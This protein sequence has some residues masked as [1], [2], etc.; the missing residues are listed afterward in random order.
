[1]SIYSY[2]ND[3]PQMRALNNSSLTPVELAD[4]KNPIGSQN[5]RIQDCLGKFAGLINSD[6]DAAFGVVQNARVPYALKAKL[7]G[8]IRTSRAHLAATASANK[9]GAQLHQHMLSEASRR[10]H[11]DKFAVAGHHAGHGGNH[12]ATSFANAAA[13]LMA[14]ASGG[15]SDMD[16][17]DSAVSSSG[18]GGGKR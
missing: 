18:I 12:D 13:S 2:G 15:S 4:L 14:Q 17:P 3:T 10:A 8:M 11:Q 5:D 7:Y 6:P 16:G 1:M 9:H